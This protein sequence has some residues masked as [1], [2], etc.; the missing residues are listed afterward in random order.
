LSTN[1]NPWK[2]WTRYKAWSIARLDR[3]THPQFA[4]RN[5]DTKNSIYIVLLNESRNSEQA[6]Y[7]YLVSANYCS[8]IK[9]FVLIFVFQIWILVHELDSTTIGWNFIFSY[10]IPINIFEISKFEVFRSSNHPLLLKFLL[11]VRRTRGHVSSCF[12]NRDSLMWNTLC[13]LCIHF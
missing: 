13:I 1:D 3:P 6:E 11:H 10:F 7:R 2:P 4:Y 9:R 8:F 5:N 12:K